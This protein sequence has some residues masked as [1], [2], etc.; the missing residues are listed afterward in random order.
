MRSVL[1]VVGILI[2]AS[3]LVGIGAAV[4]QLGETARTAIQTWGS[5]AEGDASQE[6]KS[7]RTS[8]I[9]DG[10]LQLGQSIMGGAKMLAL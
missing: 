10:I 8:K 1:V 5:V 9:V 3:I 7:T 4:W 6:G 2:L